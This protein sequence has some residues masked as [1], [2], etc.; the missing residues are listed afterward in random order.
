MRIDNSARGNTIFVEKI[1]R[2]DQ[3]SSQT[4][5]APRFQEYQEE[6]KRRIDTLKKEGLPLKPLTQAL[7]QAAQQEQ[8][9]QMITESMVDTNQRNVRE[10]I[11]KAITKS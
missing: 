2:I 3:S 4:D 10:T 7:Q 6:L 8:S 9:P 5:S 1:A 11:I